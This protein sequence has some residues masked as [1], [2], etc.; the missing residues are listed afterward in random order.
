[1]T[2]PV[3]YASVLFYAK[4][5]ATTVTGLN[6]ESFSFVFNS[7]NQQVVAGVQYSMD[8][9]LINNNCQAN[10]VSLRCTFN[11]QTQL[12]VQ[13]QPVQLIGTNSCQ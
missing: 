7:V 8:V 3:A 12:W 9:Y 4:F 11:V 5:A 6:S 13:S 10:C 1:M 2:D